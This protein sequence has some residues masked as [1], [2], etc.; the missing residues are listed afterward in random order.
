MKGAD[1]IRTVEKMSYLKD[2]EVYALWKYLN[3]SLTG[4]DVFQFQDLVA[5]E[6]GQ[7]NT[8]IFLIHHFYH[9]GVELENPVFHKNLY[10]E[11][12]SDNLQKRVEEYLE[13][14]K[15]KENAQ[16]LQNIL[17]S[18][19]NVKDIKNITSLTLDGFG[20]ADY[21]EFGKNLSKKSREKVSSF[22]DLYIDEFINGRLDITDV[23]FYSFEK[24]KEFTEFGLK[25]KKEKFGNSF[26]IKYEPNNSKM[27][28]QESSPYLFIHSIV[29]LEKLGYIKVEKVW[30]ED[31]VIPEE[32]TPD[33]KIKLTL[34]GQKKEP[35]KLKAIIS[36]SI[37]PS[38]KDSKKI[39]EIIFVERPTPTGPVYTFCI[40]GDTSDKRLLRADS[41]RI[42]T[43]IKLIKGEDIEFNK[44]LLDYLNSNL[45]CAL[46]CA[47][48]YSL[49]KIL[50]RHGRTFRVC[51]G[52]KARVIN[53]R[54]DK[55][56]QNKQART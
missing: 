11:Y 37:K 17:D 15:G 30:V 8:L 28:P 20:L 56:G 25:T 27:G 53:E 33:Y 50:E 21:I 45:N 1:E 9:W 7:T 43:F 32:Q 22:F 40:N 12:E 34:I 51:A 39:S 52:I 26:I 54:T 44:D 46:Y 49:T 19:F 18:H 2:H 3:G 14:N 36:S 24:Q 41:R 42:K 35:E 23:N 29:A 10:L 38:R 5:P 47:G 13:R 16:S 31:D 6:I 55:I 4:R 48:K